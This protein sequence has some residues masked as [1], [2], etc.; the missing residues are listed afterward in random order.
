MI[1]RTLGSAL[2]AR[3]LSGSPAP[4]TG[5]T[6]S[7]A[8][9]SAAGS[10]DVRRSWLRSAPPSAVGG[11][12]IAP[13]A[14]RRIAARVDRIPV[15]PVVDEVE[16]RPV[17]AGHV[18]RA[19][20]T[21]LERSHRMARV[22]LAPVLDQHLLGTRH[23]VAVGLE[24]REP[25]AHDAAI[26]GRTR[27]C[28]ATV[29]CHAGRAPTRSCA[30]DRGV[31]RV[32]DVHVRLGRELRMERHAEQTAI[33]EVVDVGPQIGEH[34]RGGVGEVVEHLDQAALLGHE[35]A[36]VRRE[37]ELRRVRQAGE[38]HLLPEPDGRRRAG[39]R[40]RERGGARV[41]MQQ[42]PPTGAEH[43]DPD[44]VGA[45]G[46]GRR[47]RPIDRIRRAARPRRRSGCRRTARTPTRRRGCRPR[48]PPTPSPPHCS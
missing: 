29:R 26:V 46:F 32:Q 12:R 40:H 11:V 34:G 36:T 18:Q 48:G 7:T 37:A 44:G 4:V 15:L 14:T 28:R 31:V 39:G 24:A 1:R 45:Q 35:D 19:V 17:A 20:S 38:R 27:R 43:A 6:R 8:P 13:E 2:P 16:A 25:P 5:S 41:P 47:N 22:L 23:H 3:G 30:A 33:P 9:L 10:P 21:E 42:R